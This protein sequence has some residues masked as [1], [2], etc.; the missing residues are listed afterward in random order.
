MGFD[1]AEVESAEPESS[2]SEASIAV[3]PFA[4]MSPEEDQ[5]YFCDGLSESIINSL[6]QIKDFR[7]VSRTSAFSFKGKETDIREIGN[8]LNV[9]Q[10]LEG[11]VQKAGNRLRITAQLIKV[12]DGYHIWSER[13]DRDL[14][15]VFEIQDEISVQIVNKLKVKLADQEKD[16]LVKRYTEDLE[17]YN[18][19]LKGRYYWNKTSPDGYNKGIAFF[20]EAVQKD[21]AY[22]LAYAGMAF[23]HLGLGW[24]YHLHPKEAFPR[25]REAVEKALEIDDRLSEGQTAL[26]VLKMVCDR[27]WDGAEEAFH[28]AIELNPGFSLAHSYYSM[29]FAVHG[30]HDESIAE[31]K[32][33]LELDPLTFMMS[34]NLGMRYYYARDFDAAIEQFEKVLDM[35]PDSK[36]GRFYI[37]YAYTQKKMYEKALDE[38]NIVLEGSGRKN[39]LLLATLGIIYGFSDQREKANKVLD[40]LL[41]L[42]E[43]KYVAPFFMALLYVSLDKKDQAF[44]WL[45]RS[46]EQFDHILTFLKAEPFLG[47]IRSD[48]RYDV[49]LKKMRF[50]E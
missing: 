38:I 43:E 47:S 16:M 35:Y 6:T 37:S 5:E 44:D 32:R 13:F 22:A 26:G 14:S 48:P 40:E 24:Y 3:L 15:D 19:Y 10:I 27:D 11:S 12:E 28:R 46:Y 34:I 42:S 8:K 30:R 7:V 1:V 9:S 31:G 45:E 49:L 36:I 23:C 50:T 20:Q 33:A 2:E 41:A 25:A 39:P 4:D 29:Y 21:P 17:A 18:L